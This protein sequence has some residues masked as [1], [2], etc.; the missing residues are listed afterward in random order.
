MLN[1]DPEVPWADS[2]QKYEIGGEF[3][4][5]EVRQQS[6]NGKSMI[7]QKNQCSC[8]SEGERGLWG[9]RRGFSY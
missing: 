1:S 5:A 9:Y 3:L 7:F 6:Q 4:N 8:T 2:C